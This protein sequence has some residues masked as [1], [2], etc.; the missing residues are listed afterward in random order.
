MVTNIEDDNDSGISE[1]KS[2]EIAN[3]LRLYHYQEIVFEP[4]KLSKVYGAAALAGMEDN[5]IV[6]SILARVNNSR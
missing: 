5:Y 2:N 4:I 3:L 6:F 1:A